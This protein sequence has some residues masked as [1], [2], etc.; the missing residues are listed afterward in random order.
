MDFLN[1]AGGGN[2]IFLLMRALEA[3]LPYES[4]LGRLATPPRCEHQVSTL[5]LSSLVR[6]VSKEV[7]Q[8][9]VLST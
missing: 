3:E 5:E 7:V 2:V 8:Y 1:R 4:L 9:S 6:V